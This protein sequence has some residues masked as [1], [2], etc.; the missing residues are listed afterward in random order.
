MKVA[1]HTSDRLDLESGLEEWQFILS[2]SRRW[3]EPVWSAKR[4]PIGEGGGSGQPTTQRMRME[5]SLLEDFSQFFF[6][7][8]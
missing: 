4:R 8:E 7:A 2:Q 5:S 1:I 6:S 3:K